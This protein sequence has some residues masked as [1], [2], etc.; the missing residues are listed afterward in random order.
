MYCG[1]SIRVVHPLFQAGRS[2]SSPTS[3]L[4]LHLGWILPTLGVR[5]NE[6]WH[7][8]LPCFTAPLGKFE[9][10]GA[11]HDGVFYAVAI[12][13]WPVARMLN[14]CRNEYYE[15]RRLAIAPDAPKNTASRMLRVM[16]LM[17]ARDKPLIRNLIS[18]QDTAVHSG[19]IYKAAGWEPVRKS[20]AEEWTRPSRTRRKLQSAA[21][22]VRWQI[23]IRPESEPAR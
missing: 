8:R 5:L 21:S 4:Q 23:T 18:Y 20:S 7:S 12:W 14:R 22:K 3:P 2:G 13:S 19:T 10:I 1:E 17:I 11:E 15:L 16:R 6:L 9:A